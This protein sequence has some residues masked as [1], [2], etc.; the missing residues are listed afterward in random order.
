MS[1]DSEREFVRFKLTRSIPY[2]M[3]GGE[4]EYQ[5]RLRII[6]DRMHG[7]LSKAIDDCCADGSHDLSGMAAVL[8]NVAVEILIHGEA[9]RE[10]IANWLRHTASMYDPNNLSVH[11]EPAGE[12]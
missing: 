3:R 12:A 11:S 8:V 5:N 10:G 4:R 2:T 7:G 6:R 1:D 9:D